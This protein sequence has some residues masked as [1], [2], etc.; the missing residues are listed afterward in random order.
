MDWMLLGGRARLVAVLLLFLALVLVRH[1]IAGMDERWFPRTWSGARGLG[2]YAVGDLTRAAHAYRR[3]LEV[4]TYT[5]DPS[6]EKGDG[7]VA[8]SQGDGTRAERLAREALRR[9]PNDVGAQLTLAQVELDR[10]APREALAVLGGLQ[11]RAPDQFDSWLLSSA[12]HVR[13]KE[14]G[15]A[16]DALKRALRT[17]AIESRRTSF[18]T[19]LETAG[20]L[21]VLPKRER[22]LCLLAHYHRYLRIFDRARGGTAVRYAQAAIAA[23]DRPGDAHVTIGVIHSKEGRKGPALAEFLKATEVDP[24]NPDAFR[25]LGDEYASRGDLAAAHRALRTAYERSGAEFFFAE[26]LYHFL[27]EGVGDYPAAVTLARQMREARPGD[28]HGTPRLAEVLAR[29]DEN[30]AAAA[31]FREAL[32]QD[33][34]NAQLVFGLAGALEGLKRYEESLATFAHA[35]SLAPGWYEP[36]QRRATILLFRKRYQESAREFE[37]ALDL[38]DAN[39]FTLSGLCHAYQGGG[40]EDRAVRCFGALHRYNPDAIVP[41][42]SLPE[43]LNNMQGTS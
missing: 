25:W 29:M 7:A 37:R 6:A 43:V 21:T 9:D 36:H 2:W 42:P 24:A 12:A 18:L 5:L 30:E 22:P 26:P 23:G 39:I 35:A 31:L 11:T 32:A 3:D 28:P 33:P 19:A 10:D 40:D 14:F 41:V 8:L 16:V 34:R 1:R 27:V 15:P 20:R 13:L 17:D 38:G 4:R